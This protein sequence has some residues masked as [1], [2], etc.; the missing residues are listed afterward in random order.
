MYV[1]EAFALRE[2][3]AVH[4][5]LRDCN[6]AMLVSTGEGGLTA[7]HLPFL[8][9][10]EAGP[11]GTLIGHMAR[12]NPQWRDFEGG[13]GHEVLVVF[14]GP[15]GYVSPNWYGGDPAVPTWNYQAVHVYGVPS[16]VDDPARVR[17]IVEQLISRH[18]GNSDQP[19]HLE[20]QDEAYVERMLR[21]IVAFEI[22]VSRID[23]KVKL[24]QNRSA[25]D[26]AGVIAGLERSGRAQDRELAELMRI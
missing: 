1:P 18:E 10:P 8:H 15:H 3:A 25:D 5:V 26:R 17:Q 22:P 20:S 11:K 24:S 9:E 4:R 16:L 2:R 6:F 23:A 13:D 7:T 19:W 14:A 21:G 12:A